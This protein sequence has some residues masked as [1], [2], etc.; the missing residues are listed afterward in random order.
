MGFLDRLLRRKSR[1]T[2]S[3]SVPAIP[4]AS[5]AATCDRCGKA[6]QFEGPDSA[7]VVVTFSTPPTTRTLCADCTRE[8]EKER[9]WRETGIWIGDDLPPSLK[10]L[11]P[12]TPEELRKLRGEDE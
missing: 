9:Q 5:Q 4:S 11:R 8:E 1:P 6:A 2:T 7:T 10:G 12:A 3:D